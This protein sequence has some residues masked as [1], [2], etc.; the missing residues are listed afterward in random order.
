MTISLCMI[1]KNEEA[2]LA[3]CLSSIAPYVD[4]IVIVDTGSVDDT[5]KIASIYTDSI[6]SFPW[7]NDFAAARN[8]SFSK[9]T[10]DYLL[11]VDA[12]D[13]LPK[14]SAEQFPV[15]RQWLEAHLPD[16][17]MCPYT[18]PSGMTFLRERFL[19]RES[20]FVW[21]GRVHE[22][23][24]MHGC[25]L[26]Y[27]M[28]IRHL[29]S[30]KERG[31]RNLRIYRQWEREE[32][33]SPRDEFYYGRELYYHACYDEAI[34]KLRHMVEKTDGWYVNKIEAS[35]I[36]ALCLFQIGKRTE[37]ITA[38]VG[39]FRFG[40]PRAALV[41]LIGC[42]FKA[43]KRY[44]EAIFWFETA[45]RCRDHREEGDFEEP[46]ARGIDPLLELT[47]CCYELNR[48]QCAVG[49]HKQAE[50]IAPC[51][52]AVLYNKKFFQSKGLL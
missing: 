16:L 34:T 32:T 5:Q 46:T 24:A 7:K 22:C 38:A 39:S 35:R 41:Y 43:E 45:L 49:F 48:L 13:I 3:R 26:H 36:L 14:K 40:E 20:G 25:V 12:D 33:L 6:H 30:Q 50:L 27:P 9:A 19:K 29:G 37:A 28:D 1:V 21:Q 4:E 8:F 18:V 47:Q 31:D 15:F 51:H 11:W 44:R 10:G 2:V 23:I 17:V 42:I 52:P